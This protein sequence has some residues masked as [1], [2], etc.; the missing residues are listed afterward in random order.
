MWT[1]AESRLTRGFAVL[2]TA[3]WTV[4]GATGV[5][6]QTPTSATTTSTPA[7]T[8]TTAVAPTIPGGMTTSTTRPP[9]A[10]TSPPAQPQ[11]D[12][13]SEQTTSTVVPGWTVVTLPPV[14]P[15]PSDRGDVDGQPEQPPLGPVTSPA[16]VTTS[17]VLP[18]RLPF[19]G[20]TTTTSV[21]TEPVAFLAPTTVLP[22]ST[23]VLSGGA[24]ARERGPAP[25]SAEGSSGG[26]TATVVL[27]ALALAGGLTA[28]RMKQRRIDGGG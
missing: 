11:D 24:P 23:T 14:L 5:R 20:E 4:I 25:S 27:V 7:T 1:T 26:R 15:D 21:A 12:V 17:I 16:T 19:A 13:G 6:A 18:F 2:V 28:Q 3:V 8:S 9:V 22:T 10:T